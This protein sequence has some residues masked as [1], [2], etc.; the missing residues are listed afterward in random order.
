MRGDIVDHRQGS[1]IGGGVRNAGVLK[2]PKLATARAW[3]ILLARN[4]A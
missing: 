2:N 3:H 1:V 4:S